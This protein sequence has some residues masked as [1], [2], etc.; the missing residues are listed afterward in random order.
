M[1]WGVGGKGEMRVIGCGEGL[2]VWAGGK[3]D[4]DEG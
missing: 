1:V 3:M 4:R 2:M